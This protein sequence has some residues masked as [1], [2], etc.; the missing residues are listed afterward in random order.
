[1]EGSF[2]DAHNDKIGLVEKANG[3]LLIL[4]E[5][6][7]LP[8]EVQ[9]M[10]LTFIE[11]GEYRKLGSE[12]VETATSKVV[13][14][15]NRESA[16]RDDFRYRFFPY[17]IPPLRERKGDI[18]YYFHEI[19][20]ELTKNFTKSEV[21][22]LLTHHWPGNV[23]EI[24]RIGR[25]LNRERWINEQIHKNGH[26]DKAA[27]PEDRLSHLDPRD[28]TFDP[29]ILYKILDDLKFRDV[30]IPLPGDGLF[31]RASR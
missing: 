8:K 6:G 3:G 2:T 17:Y 22:M 19:F 1:V 14:A 16:L 26:D 28:T 4:E 9:A 18:L 13:A 12:E 30:D 5:V 23:R 21:L 27:L 29:T 31:G 20:P 7:E 10:L 11:T 24:E 25:L 15:T